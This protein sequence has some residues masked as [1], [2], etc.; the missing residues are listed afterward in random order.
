MSPQCRRRRGWWVPAC[1]T[2]ATALASCGD[3][4]TT[5]PT[6]EVSA[7]DVWVESAALL[8]LLTTVGLERMT[9]VGAVPCTLRGYLLYQ[10][11]QFASAAQIEVVGC[12]LTPGA[13]MDG[14]GR[15]SVPV[16][17]RPQTSAQVSGVRFIG[18]VT[19][20][21]LLSTRQ[22]R[23]FEFLHVSAL[24]STNFPGLADVQ[25]V[26][27]T[28]DGTEVTISDTSLFME[29]ADTGDRTL[30]SLGSASLAALEERDVERIAVDFGGQMGAVLLNELHETS[31]GQHTHSDTCGTILVTPV[32]NTSTGFEVDWTECNLAT[33]LVV[34]GLFQIDAV[35]PFTNFEFVMSGQVRLGGVLPET[36]LDAM[37]WRVTFPTSGIDEFVPVTL[38]GE[39]RSGGTTRAFSLTVFW[40]T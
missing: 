37:T 27:L 7:D 28:V 33:G 15:L 5:V 12:E 35:P 32:Q 2:L 9:L 14:N 24:N 8:G 17:P 11:D 29:A 39:L 18:S 1:L 26:R 34:E 38:D 19:V 25:S 23:T 36:T 31:R 40:A 21:T 20:S 22:F 6:P 3:D 4:P 16:A 13:R 10:W 30:G